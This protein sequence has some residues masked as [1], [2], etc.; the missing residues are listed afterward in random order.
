VVAADDL[1]AQIVAVYK[2]PSRVPVV[3]LGQAALDGD[4][5]SMDAAAVQLQYVRPPDAKRPT[6]LLVPPGAPS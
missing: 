3:E 1:A 2:E 5:E 6:H 4:I